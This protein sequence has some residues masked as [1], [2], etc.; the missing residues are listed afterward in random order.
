MR[1]KLLWCQPQL[2]RAA[3]PTHLL[4]VREELCAVNLGE[5]LEEAVGVAGQRQTA[6]L[7]RL[8]SA[9]H[10]LGRGWAGEG[11][12]ARHLRVNVDNSSN[13]SESLNVHEKLKESETVS[14]N[15]SLKESVTMSVKRSRI[16]LNA[17]YDVTATTCVIKGRQQAAA[18]RRAMPPQRT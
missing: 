15:R 8:T 12:H 7:L 16:T 9:V 4:P 17:R 13:T 6:A 18:A 3:C 14:V 10:Q 5:G 2:P 1:K 11:S